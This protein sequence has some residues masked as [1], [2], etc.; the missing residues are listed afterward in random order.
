VYL[1]AYVAASLIVAPD[2]SRAT[3]T[4]CLQ[5][6]YRQTVRGLPLVSE[7]KNHF[8]MVFHAQNNKQTGRRFTLRCPICDDYFCFPLQKICL[9]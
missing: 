8:S 5:G 3:V 9:A 4:S 1:V 2:A 6:G 7:Q